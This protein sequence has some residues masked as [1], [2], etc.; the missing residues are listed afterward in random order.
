MSKIWQGQ[1]V[2]ILEVQFI[3]VN[4]LVYYEKLH[5][6]KKKLNKSQKRKRRKY[7]NSQE[8]LFVAENKKNVFV[9]TRIP[10]K[11]AV[12]TETLDSCLKIVKNP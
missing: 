3:V 12:T 6:E 1:T 11:Q 4:R 7:Q 9:V 2:S 8:T 5:L 10:N